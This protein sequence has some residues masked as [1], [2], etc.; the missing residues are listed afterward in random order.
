M[1]KKEELTNGLRER[2][3]SVTDLR[4]VSKTNGSSPA[5]NVPVESAPVTGETKSQDHPTPKMDT[6]H[7]FSRR[8]SRAKMREDKTVREN[9]K[10]RELAAAKM[11]KPKKEQQWSLKKNL[12]KDQIN[13]KKESPPPTGYTL[14][15]LVKK[16][17]VFGRPVMR[18]LGGGVGPSLCESVFVQECLAWHNTYRE[19]HNVPPL[20]TDK[21]LCLMAQS[22]ANILAHTNEF[23]HQNPP[24]VS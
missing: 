1:E 24:E 11:L 17:A 21:K 9:I 7:S 4:H 12:E 13:T 20:V 5:K 3:G 8:V 6:S 15:K 2:G 18:T 14:A 22:W 19:R 16:S 10:N 23:Y